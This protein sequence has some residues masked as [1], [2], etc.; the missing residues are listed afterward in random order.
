MKIAKFFL[1]FGL[2]NLFIL[3][4]FA[5]DINENWK[6]YITEEVEFTHNQIG[7]AGRDSSFLYYGNKGFTYEDK[8]SILNRLTFDDVLYETGTEVR[9]T[10]NE[11]IDNE[12][13]SLKKLYLQRNSPYTFFQTGD[14]FANLS[15]YSLNQNLKGAIFSVKET[16]DNPWEWSLVGG[17]AKSR[18]EY[19]WGDESDELKDTN[20]Y[21]GRLGRAKGD[22]KV[23]CNYVFTEEG[24]LPNI[25]ANTSRE[26]TNMVHNHLVS[27]DWVFKPVSGFD[28]LGES[29][30][31]RH[32]ATS[33]NNI[34]L[35]LA[36]KLR[37]K[38]RIEN[39]RT[40]IEYERTPSDFH[41]PGGSASSD[42]EIYR[43][44][45][46]YYFGDHEAFLHYT[47]Y[48]D[49]VQDSLT[50][51][52]KI[53]L[54]ETGVTLRNL[55]SR[56]TL[57]YNFKYLQKRRHRTSETMDERT[58]IM[59]TSVE[60]RLGPFLHAL[61]YENRR[62]N[63]RKDPADSGERV[64]SFAY[65][66]NSY[67]RKDD[68]TIRPAVSL[69]H[70]QLKDL[71]APASRGINRDWIWTGSLNGTFKN[72]LMFNIAYTYTQADNYALA[73]DTRRKVALCRLD[74][75][76]SGNR[77]NV[78]GIEYQDNRNYFAN[79]ASEYDENIWKLRW[80]RKF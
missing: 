18:W 19:L 48:H 2:V 25:T 1:F 73:S 26:T 75:N 80:T 5:L 52:T 62:L 63:P 55:F 67:H 72:D 79:A 4:G 60:D 8:L 31:A 10:N 17:A 50:N 59:T 39:L 3:P 43:F 40:Q 6:M 76:I 33:G 74:Y 77:D 54:P 36:H 45:N 35:G 12:D 34:D 32:H 44:R 68:W 78:V 13:V 28:L 37:S 16:E 24:Q 20:F 11:R 7:G 56:R 15:Q 58:D 14:F 66:V 69:R 65:R 22:F 27:M 53:K 70:E 9:F 51:T 30:V 64:H 49:N 29:A 41:T 38:F 46:N 42:R 23:Y 21:G 71:G 61:E 57:V 47:T